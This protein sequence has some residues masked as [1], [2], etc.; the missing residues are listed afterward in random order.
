MDN[1]EVF[2]H[3]VVATCDCLIWAL[4]ERILEASEIKAAS[5]QFSPD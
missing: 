2:C 1:G 5:P 3:A 4:D